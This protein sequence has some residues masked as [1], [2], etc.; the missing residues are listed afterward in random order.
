MIELTKEV[1]KAAKGN[2]NNRR[3]GE[4]GRCKRKA[5]KHCGKFHKEEFCWELEKNADR[6]PEGWTSIKKE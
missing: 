5:C 3:D 6:R 2:N 4:P 1:G